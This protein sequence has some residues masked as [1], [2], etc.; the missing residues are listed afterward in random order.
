MTADEQQTARELVALN[1]AAID[2]TGVMTLYLAKSLA[3]IDRMH[4]ITDAEIEATLSLFEHTKPSTADSMMLATIRNVMLK[5]VAERKRIF[6][7]YQLACHLQDADQCED[8]STG[9]DCATGTIEHALFQAL[10]IAR[11][12]EPERTD[13]LERGEKR[14]SKPSAST[15]KHVTND[16]DECVSWCPPC[17]TNRS[18]GLNPDGSDKEPTRG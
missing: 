9:D 17:T 18:R 4:M 5:L 11:R 16:F 10:V 7:I 2:P 12:D 14:R 8:H 13:P 15:E 6:P 1:D 3:E